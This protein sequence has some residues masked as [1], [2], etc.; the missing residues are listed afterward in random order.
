MSCPLIQPLENDKKLYTALYGYGSPPAQV[1]F[2]YVSLFGS[3]NFRHFFTLL[4]PGFSDTNLVTV[5]ASDY[6]AWANK[7][8]EFYKPLTHTQVEIWLRTDEPW[9]CLDVV[10]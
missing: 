9:M 3:I 10:L 5:D 6:L 7:Q 8:A 2:A 1:E 4:L